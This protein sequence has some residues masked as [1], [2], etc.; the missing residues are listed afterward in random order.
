M[1]KTSRESLDAY[2]RE[3]ESWASDR[4]DLLRAS[5]RTAWIV[6]AAAGT[7]AVC[8][9][10]ALIVL[11]PLKTVEPYTLLV[12]RHTG[13]VEALKPLDAN[14][15]APDKALTQSF[16][17]QYVIARESF[18]I[19]SLQA[20]Y[21]KTTLW[22]ADPAKAQYVSGVQVTNPASPLAR[23]PR[24]TVV[25]TRVKSVSPLGGNSTL[26]RFD[27]QRQDAGGR[28]LPVQSWVAVIRYRFSG[29]PMTRDDRFVNPLGFQV[30]GYRRDAEDVTPVEP[31]APGTAVIDSSTTT[32]TTTT[33]VPVQNG[34]PAAAPPNFPPPQRSP[35]RPSRPEVEL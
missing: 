13:F 21:R 22:S 33:E 7:I 5:R 30:T 6:A 31:V 17:V 29:E 24:S 11:T 20:N 25:S 15:I 26:V 12:D 23:Y 32:T 34:V 27:T 19:A 18:D 10:I 8:E 1:K 14:K 35:N 2:Y 9:A 3:A 4:Q 28:V 16:L